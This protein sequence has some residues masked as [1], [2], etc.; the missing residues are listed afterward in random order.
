MAAA[1]QLQAPAPGLT[2]VEAAQRLTTSGPN[3]IRRQ[4]P[5]SPLRLLAG[6]TGRLCG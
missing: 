5:P 1:Q 6:Q 4:A 3:E 2:S